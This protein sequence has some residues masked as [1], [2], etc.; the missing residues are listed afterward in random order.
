MLAIEKPVHVSERETIVVVFPAVRI[1]CM[2]NR[3][4][5]YF[6]TAIN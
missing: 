6:S 1:K 4:K 2:E 3:T 5:I